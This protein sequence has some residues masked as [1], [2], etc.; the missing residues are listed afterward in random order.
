[1]QRKNNSKQTLGKSDK[2]EFKKEKS[3]FV[4]TRE[5]QKMLEGY[6]VIVTPPTIVK[7]ITELGLAKKLTKG[8]WYYAR[9][10]EVEKAIKEKFGNGGH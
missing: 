2:G 10:E 9:R 4:T 5:I 6:G 3:I 7:W 8:G 1:M